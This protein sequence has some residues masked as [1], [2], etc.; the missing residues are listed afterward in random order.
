M[1]MPELPLEPVAIDDRRYRAASDRPYEAPEDE[2]R[3]HEMVKIADRKTKP[4]WVGPSAEL[5]PGGDGD[6]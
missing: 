1:R 2:D 4:E 3:I 6:G 5:M